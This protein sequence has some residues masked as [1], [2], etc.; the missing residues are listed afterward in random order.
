MDVG[1]HETHDDREEGG[2]LGEGWARLAQ[3]AQRSGLGHVARRC[4]YC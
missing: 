2:Q 3:E 1:P 4:P